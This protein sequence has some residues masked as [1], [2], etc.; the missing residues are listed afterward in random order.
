MKRPLAGLVFGIMLVLAAEVD[1]AKKNTVIENGRKVTFDYT[2]TVEGDVV[3]T[4]HGEGRQ[5]FTY[6]HGEKTIVPGLSRQLEGLH[7]GDEKEIVVAPE[8]AYGKMN[9][10]AFQEVPKS[11][12]PQDVE[13][14]VG[15]QLQATNQ[16][17]QVLLVTVS[18]VKKETV[19]LDFNHPLAGKELRFNVKII[20]IK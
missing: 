4:S 19:I 12:L 17:G 18:E 11:Q 1:A 8:E 14:N 5:P 10:D 13:L 15:T 9:Q 20:G 7:V 16:E 3:D 6:T 2:L